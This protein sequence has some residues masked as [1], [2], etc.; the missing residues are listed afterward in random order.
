V[1][2]SGAASKV[3]GGAGSL[4]MSSLSLDGDDAVF[5]G[6]TAALAPSRSVVD[7]AMDEPSSRAIVFLQACVPSAGPSAGPSAPSPQFL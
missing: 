2:G 7:S 5:V 3:V 4:G 6:G 1:G